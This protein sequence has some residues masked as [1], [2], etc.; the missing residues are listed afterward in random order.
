MANNRLSLRTDYLMEISISRPAV[1]TAV[2]GL[3]FIRDTDNVIH[4]AK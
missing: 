3:L 2:D 4:F 1:K